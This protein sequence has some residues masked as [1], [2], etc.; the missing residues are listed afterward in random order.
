MRKSRWVGLAVAVLVVLSGCAGNSATTE[1]PPVTAEN[2]TV[3]A[4]GDVQTAALSAM[5]SVD[6]YTANQTTTI[7]RQ[8]D[9]ANQT[10]TVSVSYA[11]N[12]SEQALVSN[13]ST[14]GP[15]GTATETRY[16]VDE[17]L[18]QHS[19]TFTAEY[20][21]AWISRDLSDN[22]TR[23]WELSDQLWRYQFT[24][25]NA[26]L[27]NV[28]TATVDGRETY[29]VTASVDTD[30]LNTALRESLDLPPGV[31][32]TSEGNVS[33][34]ATFWIDTD[35]YRPVQVERTLTE[36]RTNDGETVRVT[37]DVKTSLAYG[38]VSVSLP[39]AAENAQAIGDQ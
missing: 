26:T 3:P 29:V 38:T 12:R 19:E 1:G 20:G 14:T 24:M 6:G 32:L 4:A 31:A 18:Y 2:G 28:S 16:L 35:T 11:V 37:R 7:V 36:T 15:D 9:G 34:E 39:D 21:T 22:P 23:Y 30:E 13:R 25:G 33:L 5:S 8:T 27:S 10:T 17:T